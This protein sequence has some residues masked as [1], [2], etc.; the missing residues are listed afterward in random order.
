MSSPYPRPSS[1]VPPG[2]YRAARA[3]RRAGVIALVLVI[4]YVG[5][6][7]YS[8]FQVVKTRP[9]VGTSTTTLEPNGTVGV[10]TSFTLSDPSDLPIQ[11]FS[12]QFRILNATGQLL[13][14]SATP[15]VTVA[16]GG[17]EVVP[18]SIFVP[19]TSSG[20]S[21]LVNDQY[22]RWDVWGNA[23]FGYLFPVSIGVDANRSWG[24]PFA[25]L[26]VSL[27]APALMGGI[28]QVPVTVAFSNNADFADDGALDFEV[29]SSTATIC[30]SGSFAVDV[31]PGQPYQSTQ[32]IDLASDCNPA[33]GAVEAQYVEDGATIPLPSEPIP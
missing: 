10:T 11:D 6:V 8:A 23:T 17:S 7:G 14:D 31:P 15:A 16:S 4:V 13:L 18:V 21:L 9:G 1:R 29:V 33:G 3:L 19:L 27:G 22:L 26:T 28:V 25:N 20:E 24:A 32:N 5:F 12:L 2:I 30:G